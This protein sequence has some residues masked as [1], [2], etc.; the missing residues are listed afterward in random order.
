MPESFKPV[1]GLLCERP[2]V[3]CMAIEF[4]HVI[5]FEIAGNWLGL[6]ALKLFEPA[7]PAPPNP[8]LFRPAG[9]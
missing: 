6:G 2:V 9:R 5:G 4:P 7:L 3:V 8:T 1:T